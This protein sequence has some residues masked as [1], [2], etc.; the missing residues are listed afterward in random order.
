M[1]KITINILRDRIL[2]VLSGKVNQENILTFTFC[3][4]LNLHIVKW[5]EE[6]N[7]PF[8]ICQ[9]GSGSITSVVIVKFTDTK[10]AVEF[11]LR[12]C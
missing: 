9:I 4:D 6:Q 11:K 7:I 12:F 5:L 8:E 3:K 2:C 1:S 10:L